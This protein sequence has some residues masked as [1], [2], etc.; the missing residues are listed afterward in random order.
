MIKFKNIVAAVLCATA[1]LSLGACTENSDISGYYTCDGMDNV[2]NFTSDGRIFVND[3]TESYSR[4]EIRGGKIITYID[5]AEES[6]ME[7]D[8]KK[9]DD[10]FK[11]GKLEYRKM[12]RYQS[13]IVDDGA[14]KVSE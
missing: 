4:Y 13:D 3:E 12:G 6:E 5:G 14:D 9:T 8:F 10:G 2:Y 11:M 7:F 1:L